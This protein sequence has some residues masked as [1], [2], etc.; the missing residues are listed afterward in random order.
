MRL[1]SEIGKAG[2]IFTAEGESYIDFMTDVDFYES[3]FKM[4]MQMKRPKS[5]FR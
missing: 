2:A 3:P 1:D 4:C 5:T